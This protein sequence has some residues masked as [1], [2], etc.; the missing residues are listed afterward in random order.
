M[1]PPRW[2][3]LLIGAALV[4]GFVAYRWSMRLE[5]LN[6][7][8][9][10][11]FWIVDSAVKGDHW[12]LAGEGPAAGHQALRIGLLPLL[13]PAIQWLGATATAF[14]TVPI[15]I[16][17]LGFW[18]CWRIMQEDAG[19]EVAVAFAVFHIALPFELRHASLLLTD[20]PSAV[21]VLLCIHLVHRLSPAEHQSL[22]SIAWRGAL[23]GLV[24]IEAYLLRINTLVFLAPAFLFFVASSRTR[25]VAL[26]T[27]AMI[28]LGVLLEQLFYLSMGEPFGY[29]WQTVRQ[30]LDSYSPFLPLLAPEDFLGRYFR[31]AYNSFNGGF[32]GNFMRGFLVVSLAAH[33]FALVRGRL[34]GCALASTGLVTFVATVYGIYAWDESGIRALG[35]ESYRYLQLF[36]YTSIVLLASSAGALL[37]ATAALGSTRNSVRMALF[38][39]LVVLALVPFGISDRHPVPRVNSESGLIAR[40]TCAMDRAGESTDRVAVESTAYSSRVARLFRGEWSQP[41]VDWQLSSIQDVSDPDLAG[42]SYMFFDHLR[43]LKSVRYNHGD[44]YKAYIDDLGRLDEKLWGAYTPLNGLA[45]GTLYAPA[46]ADSPVTTQVNWNSGPGRSIEASTVIIPVDPGARSFR[47][48]ARFALHPRTPERRGGT[49][50]SG[51]QRIHALRFQLDYSERISVRGWLYENIRGRQIRHKLLIIPSW[52]TIRFEP[53]PGARYFRLDL[54]FEPGA[55]ESQERLSIQHTELRSWPKPPDC[56]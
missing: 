15:A 6:S 44:R 50:R 27:G 22:S 5:P 19:T 23:A 9:L 7:D 35:P 45:S 39:M 2:T 13:A 26:S 55:L 21:F 11:L 30:A 51:E 17:T 52:N 49:S 54:L 38:A 33:V 3:T 56:S 16:S 1:T 36:F 24:G 8:D 34:P 18:L 43:L 14:Y 46:S 28:A 53:R 37:R 48:F 4:A 12:L 40:I 31:F 42:S 29:R 20:L 10:T 25:W 32:D 47:L 41:R